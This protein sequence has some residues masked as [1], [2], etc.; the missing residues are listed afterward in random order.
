MKNSWYSLKLDEYGIFQIIKIIVILIFLFHKN[1]LV[2]IMK[3][4]ICTIDQVGI[5]VQ[6]GFRWTNGVYIK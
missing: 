3:I 6:D 1:C 5:L 4:I 2:L